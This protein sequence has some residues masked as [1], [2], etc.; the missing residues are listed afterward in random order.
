MIVESPTKAQMISSFL[1]SEYVV[2]SSVG[3]IR[4]LP[5]NA[6]DI[7]AKYK[8]E[9]WARLGVDV[10]H[11]FEPIYV[12][13]PD[14][15]QQVARL[16]E[17]LKD[18]SQ[19]FLATD[20]DRE[21]EA[22]AWHL[23]QTLKPKVPVRR[24]VFHEITPQAIADAVA[25]PR[26]LDESLVDAQET[27]RILDR[28]YGYEVSPVLWKKVMPRLSA[29]RVQSVFT[30]LV[31][32]R[33]RARL[34]F[35]AAGY[36]D[37][38][39]VFDTGKT[40]TATEPATVTANLVSLDGRRLATGRDFDPDTGQVR[41]E[42]LQ[43]D[44]ASARRVA[45]TLTGGAFTVSRVE[46]KP[47][48]RKP[49]PPFI[50]STLQQE[51]GRKLRFSAQRVMRTAQRL[52]ENGYITYMRTDSTNLSETALTAARGQA[53][54][55]YGDDYVPDK[56]RTYSRKV[57]NAQEAHE[58]IR[59]AGDSFRT[60]GSVA[61]E[62]SADE[63]RL[64][65]LVWQRTVA[66]QMA[67]ARG[68]RTTIRIESQA[69]VPELGRAEFSVSGQTITFPGFLRA[70]V[71]QND[72]ET[73]ERDDA[74][75]RLPRVAEGDGLTGTDMTPEGHTTSPPARYTEPSLV[76]ALEELGIG[77]PSTYANH[78]E[79]IK[80]RGY[81]WKKGAALVPTW[82][83]F[84]V[85]GLLETYFTRLV[86]YDFTASMEDDLDGIA[87]GSQPGVDWL[88]RFYFG[89]EAGQ[90]GGI[91]RSG[92][93]KKLVSERLAE[94]DARGVNSIPIRDGVVVR[95]GRYGP[96]LQRGEDGDRASVP[97][98][99][100][101]DELTDEKIEE[102]LNAPSDDRVLGQHP[103]SGLDVI[104][105]NGRYGPYVTVAL[106]EGSKDKP[107]S[108]SLFK[109]MALDTLTL[110]DALKLLSLP[111]VLGK[112]GDGEEV[113]AQNGRYGPYVKKGKESRSLETEDQ[114]F[115]VT[116]EEAEKLIAQPK[117]RG[118]RAAAAPPLR[119]VGDDPAT[120]KPMVIKDGRFG[121]YVTDGET[122][123]SLRKGD[124]VEEIT[125][126]RAA[127]LLADRRA[128]G[129]APKKRAAKKAPAKKAAPKK[130]TRA[131]AKTT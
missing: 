63:F 42:A 89:S 74:E 72:D 25:N 34:R 48:S 15:R 112:D 21:G 36:W 123:A 57:K 93:L 100:A 2:E 28:L 109:S 80:D 90:E 66:S 3:H 91:A 19:V 130:T 97:E 12:I 77:R 67:D 111:R 33:E 119:E 30:R 24:M 39:G 43:L 106:P 78:L 23:I 92:G 60:P 65:E 41:S 102:L 128:R 116:L 122:N 46:E 101:P 58:A 29:G 121:P 115:S 95:V 105:K 76:K 27:R 71:E 11:G 83:A 129:P 124:E 7:P 75:R 6:A 26:E 86:D 55:L 14:R 56:P 54:E 107:A 1:G 104:A 49:Y 40:A 50:T 35:V 103:E 5:R 31:V 20:E 125:L 10:D 51:G 32:E 53:R 16:K 94:I 84:A 45:D 120:G 47:Y 44:E 126:D 114:L 8:G 70:Y 22:I 87:A 37:V 69:Q 64:Y 113:T 17:L 108:S 110:E 81:V 82:V 52:Y 85:V 68:F 127:E 62:L 131:R 118:N 61:N 96:Y 13:S 18:A 9:S 117:Q 99:I 73:A 4:D 79:N 38:E 59:P 98:D 88:T